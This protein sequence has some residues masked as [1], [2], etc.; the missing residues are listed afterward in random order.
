MIRRPPRSPPFPY[1]TLFRS[2]FPVALS[3]ASYQTITVHYASANG[4]AT[5]PSDYTAVSGTLTFAPGQTAKT[6]PKSTNL[7]ST[8]LQIQDSAFSLNNPT[9][10]ILR[11]DQAT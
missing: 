7:N 8:N 11:T 4:T 1:T 6:D 2:D 5:A 9:N 10:A 3:N